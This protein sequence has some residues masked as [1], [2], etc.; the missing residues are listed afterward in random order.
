MLSAVTLQS[1]LSPLECS[2][3]N[4]DRLLR[5]SANSYGR[6]QL[7]VAR[8]RELSANL[9]RCYALLETSKKGRDSDLELP[10]TN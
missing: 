5:N 9:R 10:D 2:S 6:S 7:P 8:E 3:S 4:V 1:F